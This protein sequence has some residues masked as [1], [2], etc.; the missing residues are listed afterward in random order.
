MGLLGVT[1]QQVLNAVHKLNNRPGKCVGYKTLYEV[2][3]ELSGVEIEK[4]LGY[5][6]IT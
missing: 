2:F 3:H 6:F 4:W 1:V 5:T